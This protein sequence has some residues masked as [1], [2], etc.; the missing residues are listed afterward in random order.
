MTSTVQLPPYP[1]LDEGNLSFPDGRYKPV[2]RSLAGG[3]SVEVSHKLEGAPLLSRL[4]DERRARFACLLSAPLTGYRRFCLS[5]ESDSD[6]TIEW[7]KG[8]VGEPPII[9]PVLVAVEDI[10]HELSDK[11]GVAG[12]WQGQTVE[13]PKGGRLARADFLRPCASLRS[14]LYIRKNADRPKGSFKVA[15][16]ENEG[17]HFSVDVAADLHAFLQNPGAHN[18]LYSSI[19]AHM[20]SMC[21]AILREEQGTDRNNGDEKWKHHSNLI[22]LA[23]L[24]ESKGLP[25]WS[26]DD[27]SP[28]AVAMQLHPLSLPEDDGDDD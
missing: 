2:V 18:E 17:F 12:V 23:N 4:V 22:M 9:R 3:S 14:L 21:F 15:S 8:E 1:A 13:F 24:L 26:D 6:Q 10:R 25:H 19:A 20:V 16:N 28:D 7:E 27:F 11:D 5:A